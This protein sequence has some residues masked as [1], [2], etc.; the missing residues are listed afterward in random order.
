MFKL[1]VKFPVAISSIVHD[2]TS[3][4]LSLTVQATV[5]SKGMEEGI[6]GFRDSI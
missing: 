4:S 3:V 1:G 6:G 5:E 2:Q